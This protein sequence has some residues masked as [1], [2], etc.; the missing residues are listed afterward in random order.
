MPNGQSQLFI[1]NDD[2]VV[3]L[4]LDDTGFL[5]FITSVNSNVYRV[6]SNGDISLFTKLPSAKSIVFNGFNRFLYIGGENELYRV[7]LSGDVSIIAE[8]IRPRGLTFDSN[9]VLYVS[10][11]SVHPYNS[12]YPS[13]ILKIY[14]SNIE[15]EC[16]DSDVDGVIDPW[17]YCPE[18]PLNS[19][20]NSN[21]CPLIDNSALSGR[22]SIKGQPLTQ[23]TATL[24]QSG[25]LFQKSPLDENGCFKFDSVSEKKSIN[26][27]IRRPIE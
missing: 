9:G 10:D 6:N 1:N 17:D 26:L 25:E 12:D 21:G 27:M 2:F 23:G 15:N 14:R 3:A 13:R 24:F 11:Q 4:T 22:I 16:I 7:S 18:T 8:D 20:V 5:Y 19:Y